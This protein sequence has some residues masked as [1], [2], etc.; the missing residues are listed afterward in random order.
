M[1]QARA[2]IPDVKQDLAV[3]PLSIITLKPVDSESHNHWQ[4]YDCRVSRALFETVRAQTLSLNDIKN[5]LR[6]PL[7]FIQ[8]CFLISFRRISS[9]NF[10]FLTLSSY[11]STIMTSFAA[12]FVAKK[13]FNER[14]SNKQGTE[15]STVLRI[16]CMSLN[17][18]R[19]PSSKPYQPRDSEAYTRPP[20]SNAGHYHPA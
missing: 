17:I 7:S 20:R 2:T 4:G 1:T 6:Q 14:S 9:D 16:L 10:S 8:P 3:N 13:L 12:K 5:E 11:C 18:C 15:V 19:I